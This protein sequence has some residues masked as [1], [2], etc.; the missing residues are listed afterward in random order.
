[1]RQKGIPLEHQATISHSICTRTQKATNEL[2]AFLASI[3]TVIMEMCFGASPRARELF[4]R[5]ILKT[6]HTSLGCPLPSANWTWPR[7]SWEQT[8][9][10]WYMRKVNIEVTSHLFHPACLSSNPLQAPVGPT[11]HYSSSRSLS[12]I[13]SYVLAHGDDPSYNQPFFACSVHQQWN[14]NCFSLSIYPT[15]HHP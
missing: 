14:K 11:F 5:A 4:M 10:L 15:I 3:F 12:S 7:D 13:Q 2:F 9:E 8:R 6:R 1:M